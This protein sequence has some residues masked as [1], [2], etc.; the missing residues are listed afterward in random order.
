MKEIKLNFLDKVYTLKKSDI[1]NCTY[2]NEYW[3]CDSIEPY[4]F[5]EF[6]KEKDGRIT[7]MCKTT[8]WPFNYNELHYQGIELR[9]IRMSYDSFKTLRKYTSRNVLNSD[10]F[11]RR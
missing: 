1:S 4:V 6:S 7:A 11:W 9:S 8:T 3:Y 5:V 2:N 10:L